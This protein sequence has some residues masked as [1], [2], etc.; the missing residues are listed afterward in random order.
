VQRRIL[1]ASPDN[2]ARAEQG[3]TLLEVVCVLAILA[4]LAGLV[5]PLLP[6]TTS[7]AR[8]ES[9]AVATAALLKSDRN[10][11]LRR[12]IEIETEINAEK[13]LVRSGATG[14]SLLIPDDVSFEALLSARCNR[15]LAGSGV[16]FFPSG[17]SC[18]GVVALSRSANSYEIRINWLTGGIEVVSLNPT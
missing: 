11:A 7:R 15:T 10:A 5:F 1:P 8:L 12:Q 4:I 3:F 2:G 13:R 14:R 17:M 18:G 9:Y 16:T 6:H